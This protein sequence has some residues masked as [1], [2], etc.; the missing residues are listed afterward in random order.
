[1][2]K[3]VMEWGDAP[4]TEQDCDCYCNIV[5]AGPKVALQQNLAVDRMTLADVINGHHG[6]ISGKAAM[7][8]EKIMAYLEHHN[9]HME[10]V[11]DLIATADHPGNLDMEG[12]RAGWDKL[13]S[14][15]PAKRAKH[16]LGLVETATQGQL[17]H[18]L[19]LL[20]EVKAHGRLHGTSYSSMEKAAAG[21]SDFEEAVSHHKHLGA[22]A[23]S[24]H[25]TMLMEHVAD[26]KR[27]LSRIANA[28][29]S[30]LTASALE[31][32]SNSCH[33]EEDGKFCNIHFTSVY[34]VPIERIKPGM[35]APWGG[36]YRKVRAVL[37][38]LEYADSDVPGWAQ[39]MYITFED[40]TTS[41]HRGKGFVFD[42][43]IKVP[44]GMQVS[45][46]TLSSVT[47]EFYNK[48]HQQSGEDGGEFTEGPDGPGRKGEPGT[49]DLGKK[50]TN[51]P[52]GDEVASSPSPAP[53][54][55][56]GRSKVSVGLRGNAN[57]SMRKAFLKEKGIEEGTPEYDK[58]LSDPKGT[59]ITIK[60]DGG[61]VEVSE[62]KTPEE[63]VAE[64]KTPEKTAPVV[65]TPKKPSP[66]PAPA[67]VVEKKEPPAPVESK[68][69][70]GTGT[71]IADTDYVGDFKKD[72]AIGLKE[73]EESKAFVKTLTKEEKSAVR[74]YLGANTDKINNC[75]EGKGGCTPK[76]ENDIKVINEV[77]AKSPVRENT[78][79]RG[80]SLGDDMSADDA[81]K[82]IAERFKPGAEVSM[83]QGGVQS[84]STSVSISNQYAGYGH[85]KVIFEVVGKQQNAPI[86]KASD[87]P[88]SEVLFSPTAKFRVI[89]VKPD[90]A[91]GLPHP[92]GVVPTATIVRI[93]QILDKGVTASAKNTSMSWGE[94]W[95][96][97]IELAARVEVPS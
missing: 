18:A 12:K 19:E 92:N 79:Y 2:N 48:N 3:R 78:T 97:K 30:G 91:V 50:G 59:R 53:A 21:H 36:K 57:S 75:M 52:K 38:A 22:K 4:V 17:D 68:P 23:V 25:Q 81:A 33:S 44:E 24:S 43:P 55:K 51:D 16:K 20:G 46:S 5:A 49:Q 76:I 88:F 82:I 41:A 29:R 27:L 85:G 32:F 70:S 60:K 63:P 65:E 1:M 87:E 45:K 15:S 71:G 89:E 84:A 83:T 37:N 95:D 42:S 13:A 14:D 62:K 7:L 28:R 11:A 40:G 31:E 77:I 80:I 67:S 94:A 8:D 90:V 6:E 35:Y 56:V 39:M 96:H 86:S 10:K 72:T 58:A 26:H 93:E 47:E 61:A 64:K 69:K 66:A 9:S 54:P 73:Q 74:S 34:D